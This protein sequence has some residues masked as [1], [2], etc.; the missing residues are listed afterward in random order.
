MWRAAAGRAG[1]AAAP[2]A[3][4][5]QLAAR[6]RDVIDVTMARCRILMAPRQ[7]EGL[8]VSY[9]PARYF[10]PEYRRP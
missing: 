4:L 8:L 7:L 10:T 9:L 2:G 1:A 6:T 5:S 3:A